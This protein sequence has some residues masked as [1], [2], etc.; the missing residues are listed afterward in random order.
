MRLVKEMSGP[1]CPFNSTCYVPG[2]SGTNSGLCYDQGGR[3]T[4]GSGKL[5]SQPPLSD[6]MFSQTGKNAGLPKKLNDFWMARNMKSTDMSSKC[7][8]GGNGNEWK[9]ATI[10]LAVSTGILLLFLLLCV[11]RL[12][13][14]GG[15]KK[16][17]KARK[18][19]KTS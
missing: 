9:I 19:R 3:P 13:M 5:L 4:N 12:F 8:G 11:F 7:G 10:V 17:R 16:R 18:A 2:T 15:P 6:D 1:W 14:L